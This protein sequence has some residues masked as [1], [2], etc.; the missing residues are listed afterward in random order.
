M[1][2]EKIRFYGL[3][4]LALFKNG[5]WTERSV[6]YWE[7]SASHCGSKKYNQ[8]VLSYNDLVSLSI[9]LLKQYSSPVYF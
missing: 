5:R 7:V 2:R 6:L 9:M 8:D 4:K 3:C 1:R